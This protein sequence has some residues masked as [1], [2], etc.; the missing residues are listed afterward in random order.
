LYT[1]PPVFPLDALP[2]VSGHGDHTKMICGGPCTRSTLARVDKYTLE[3]SQISPH[4][5]PA[6]SPL[7]I[8]FLALL[9][10]RSPASSCRSRPP[11]L[12]PRTTGQGSRLGFMLGIIK[13]LL[14]GGWRQREM[15]L[16]C[17]RLPQT[18]LLQHRSL[19]LQSGRRLRLSSSMPRAP[20]M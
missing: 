6:C 13:E 16:Q 14:L 4:I 19:L 7:V 17:H 9:H 8:I 2:A 18:S 5:N 11:P 3:T 10:C 15:R 1:P 12:A 20:P